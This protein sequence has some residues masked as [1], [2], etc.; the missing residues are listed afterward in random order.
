MTVVIDAQ[1]AVSCLR[2]GS[3]VAVPTDTVYGLAAS[4][5]RPDAVATLFQ[6]KRRPTSVALP[7]LVGSRDVIDALG[8]SWPEKARQTER[9]PVARGA[10]DCRARRSAFRGTRRRGGIH[11]ISSSE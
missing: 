3:V 1:E 2:R 5:E 8:V 11:R 7:V 6:L 9:R 4:L 10:H